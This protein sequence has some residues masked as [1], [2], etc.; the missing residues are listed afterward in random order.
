[1]NNN[2]SKTS[3]LTIQQDETKEL[4]DCNY[5]FTFEIFEVLLYGI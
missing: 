3:A 5:I 1:M 4:T 2:F